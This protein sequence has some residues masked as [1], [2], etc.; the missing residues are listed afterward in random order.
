M[1]FSQ[2][3]FSLLFVS[4]I[5]S[6]C[7]SQ[8]V[9]KDS[10]SNTVT[11]TVYEKNTT[12]VI[13]NALIQVK[14][15]SR[16]VDELHTDQNG[17]F[18]MKVNCDTRYI[19]SAVYENYTKDILLVFTSKTPKEHHIK[20]EIIPLNEFKIANGNKI[21]NIENPIEFEPDDY[22]ITSYVKPDLEKILEIL[23]KYSKLQLEIAVHTNNMGNFEFLQKLSQER[24]IA[25]AN[26]FY[27][28]GIDRERI[29]PVGYG[30]NKPV[31]ECDTE[32]MKNKTKKCT[33]NSRIE[34]VVT[35]DVIE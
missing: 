7:Y 10:C 17:K 11:G 6:N 33:H 18:S 24:A 16:I 2:K 34:F 23:N 26:Y 31:P 12:K 8:I 22:R 3:F 28:K 14:I 19:Y 20:L 25:L 9:L 30:F 15:T 21:L 32:E 1:N 27:D 29:V 13:P 35:S 4:I 5:G